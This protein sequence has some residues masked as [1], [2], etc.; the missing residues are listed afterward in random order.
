MT[1]DN[2]RT[3]ISLRIRV[4][5]ATIIFLGYIVLAYIAKL[6][7]FPF[8][9]LSDTAWTLLLICIYFIIA[10][11]PMVLNYQYIYF[12]DDGDSIII[13]YFI[14]GILGGKKNSVEINK[15][16]FEGFNIES[17]FFG[18]IQSIILFQRIKG[19]IAKYPP[20]YISVLNR[21]ERSKLLRSLNLYA[22]KRA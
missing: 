19:G 13:R 17:R 7:K 12:S 6:I 10:F 15:N 9:G 20:I 22:P 16:T 11:Y 5:F 3:I 14:S 8:L 4:F 21:K 18:F 2:S 1:F